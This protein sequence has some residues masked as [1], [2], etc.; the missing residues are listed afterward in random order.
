M[1]ITLSAFEVSSF[2]LTNS[3]HCLYLCDSGI[4]NIYP[5]PKLV[6]CHIPKIQY[7]TCSLHLCTIFISNLKC[8]TLILTGT[9]RHITMQFS[10]WP[11]C[12]S[13]SFKI[14]EF[15]GPG[16]LNLYTLPC[17]IIFNTLRSQTSEPVILRT[18]V[19]SK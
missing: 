13:T 5:L 1:D 9:D 12:Q 7:G 15:V 16:G 4:K 3:V 19:T 17:S 6:N 10:S 18:T 11:N 8:T 2:L 14:R